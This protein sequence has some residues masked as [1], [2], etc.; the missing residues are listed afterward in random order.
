MIDRCPNCDRPM[1]PSDTRCFHCNTPIAGRGWP[2]EEGAELA[3]N[4]RAA[5]RL[6]IVVLALMALGILLMN[7]MGVGL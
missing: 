7:W 2:D 4:I 3:P 5:A 1:L 6:A